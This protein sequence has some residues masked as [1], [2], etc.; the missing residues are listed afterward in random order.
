MRRALGIEVGRGWVAL[1]EVALG[2]DGAPRRHRF[3]RHEFP[4]GESP[5]PGDVADA[6]LRLALEAG[7]RERSAV[8]ALARSLTYA[9][10][11]QLPPLGDED[12]LRL[13]SLQPE[14][15][16]LLK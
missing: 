4:E 13:V 15:F 7:A 11:V 8:L 6:C 3:A 9:K 10:P 16:F 2:G 12:R 14:R 1:C 5:A